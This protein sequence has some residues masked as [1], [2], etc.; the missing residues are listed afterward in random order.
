MTR[1]RVRWGNIAGALS[2][3]ASFSVALAADFDKSGTRPNTISLP[4]GPGS[5]EGMGPSFEPSLNDGGARYAIPLRLPPGPAGLVPELELSYD[6]GR[7]NGPLGFGWSLSLPFIQRQTDKGIPQ[8]VDGPNGVDDDLDGEFD[9]VDELDRCIT[10]HNEELVPLSNGYYFAE[11]E[12]TFIRYK[13]VGDGWEGQLPAGGRLYFG[14]NANSRIFDPSAPSNTFKWLLSRQTDLNGNTIT[15]D[16]SDFPGVADR[17]QKYLVAVR[18]GPGAGPPWKANHLAILQYGPRPDVL[19][20]GRGGFLIRTGQRLTNVLIGTQGVTLPG[21]R[22]ADLDGDGKLDALNRS[23]ALSYADR[24][25]AASAW[26]MLAEVTLFGADGVTR[27]PPTAFAYGLADPTATVSAADAI[28]GGTNEPVYGVD[29]GLVEFLDVNGDALPDILKTAYQG[30]PHIVYLNEGPVSD[31]PGAAIRWGRPQEMAS[32][33]GQAWNVNLEDTNTVSHLADLD[34]D[35]R[36]DLWYKTPGG[37]V[38][39]FRN[40]ADLSWGP[41]Q[42]MTVQDFAPPAPFGQTGVTTADLDFDKRIDI[43]QSIAVGGHTSFRTWYARD[44]ERYSRSSTVEQAVRFELAQPG[45][46]LT[47]FNGDR[48]PD[49]TRLRSSAVEV[50]AGLGYGRFAETKS[51][52][53]QEWTFTADEIARAK[54]RDLT[55]DGLPELVLERA[56]PGVLWYWINLGDYRFGPR[57][58]VTG[59]P[60]TVSRNAAVRWVDINGNGT[61]DLIYSD[62]AGNPRIMAVDIGQL[63]G[64]GNDWNLL[65]LIDNGIGLKTRIDYAPSTRFRLADKA[66][67]NHWRDPLPFPVSV[68]SCVVF[69]DSLG[70]AYTN[71]YRYRDGYYDPVEKEFRG[72]A[73]A[74]AVSH[75]AAD[76]PSL[77]AR[78]W[79]DT[80]RD[81][82]A[83]KG[84]LLQTTLAD[85]A[86]GIFSE[87]KLLWAEMPRTLYTGL[88]TQV[89]RFAHRTGSE[90]T[91]TEQGRGTPVTIKTTSAWDNFGNQVLDAN[92]GVVGNQFDDERIVTNLYAINEGAWLVRFPY[93]TLLMDEAGAVRSRS[94]RFY[95]DESFSGLNP[96]QVTAGRLTMVRDWID[97][98]SATNF[99]ES[100]RNQY[101]AR[102]N[103]IRILDP[104]ARLAAGQPQP[105]AGHYRELAYDDALAAFPLSETIHVGAGSDPLVYKAAFDVGLGTLTNSIDFNGHATA[106]RHDPLGRLAAILKPGDDPAFPSTEYDYQL[107]VPAG[108]SHLVNFVE[109]RLLDK[110][111]GSAG[112]VKR[113]HYLL[114]RAFVDGMGRVLLTKQEA[115]NGRVAVSGAGPFN[116]RGKPAAK[117]NP[118]FSLAGPDFE[119]RLAFENIEAPGWT[120]LFE[121]NGISCPLGLA[122]A[123]KVA[124]AYD[125][126]LREIK[127]TH[128]D[129]SFART[130]HEPLVERKYDEN[131]TDPA[132]PF[133]DTPHV[134]HHDG[135]G[136]LIQVDEIVRLND[137][138]TPSAVLN[139]WSTC[140][141]YDL[142]DQ[143]T[144]ILDSQNNLKTFAY[145]G[146]KR[147]TRLDD[148]NRGLMVF[149]YDAASNLRETTDAKNQLI[150]YGYDGANRL[151][152]EDYLDDHLSFSAH[153]TNDVRYVYDVPMP[154]IPMGD[155]TTAT[156][157]NTLGRLVY[158]IDLSGEEHT[159]YD[160][161]GRE[162]WV[163]KRIVNPANGLLT[164]YATWMSYDPADRLAILTYPDHDQLRHDYDDRGLLRKLE[165]G[166]FGVVISNKDYHA[167]GRMALCDYG[168][169]VRTSHT[170]DNRL[171]LHELFT[172]RV[173]DPENALLHFGY[174]FDRSINI[175]QIDDLRPGTVAPRNDPG[176][177]TQLYAYDDLNRLT[178]A[179]Y[180]FQLPG[181]S[182]QDDGR[183]HYRYDRIGNMLAQTSTLQQVENGVP[184]T[185]VGQME[186]GGTAG[187]WNRIGRKPVDP[188]GPHA[189][190]LV[191]NRPSAIGHR[192]FS[193]DANGN[194]LT[195]DGLA[196]TWDFRDRLVMATNAQ[197]VAIYTYDYTGRRIAKHIQ[198]SAQAGTNT[199]ADARYVSRFYELR[200]TAPP[201]RYAWDGADCV[202]RATPIGT[203]GTGG[204]T[205]IVYYGQDHLHSTALTVDRAGRPKES[206]AYHPFGA[207]RRGP[208]PAAGGHIYGFGQKEQDAETSLANFE[209]RC[210]QPIL[211]RFTAVDPISIGPTAS[212]LAQPQLLNAY[213]YAGNQPLGFHDPDG[214]SATVIGAVVGGI[215]FGLAEIIRNDKLTAGSLGKAIAVGIVSGAFAGS[216]IDSGGATLGLAGLS[217]AGTAGALA[218]TAA[219]GFT[220]GATALGLENLLQGKSTGPDELM[221]AGSVSAAASVVGDLSG[222]LLSR[223]A[224]KLITRSAAKGGGKGLGNPF[225]DKTAAQID[226][227]FTKKGY[228]KIGPDP[229]GGTGGYV[230]P[231]TGRSYHIDPKDWGKYREPNHVDVNRLRDYKGPLDKKKLPY[232]EE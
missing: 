8:Y 182:A 74:E 154:A 188:P 49:Q 93:R 62:S 212:S 164:S 52:P 199:W 197:M 174:T 127:L 61:T 165:G 89:V 7:G 143:L 214:K 227:M 95:D 148:P 224:S 98:A 116:R 184:V 102:G 71:D 144:T 138:G 17:A 111:P 225:K 117:L 149:V 78:S 195:I 150:R 99:V 141:G 193:Y 159:S 91:I 67:T 162:C 81:F 134:Y 56:A 170:Y 123:P 2:L 23:Y 122:A 169:G 128:P 210:L 45:V 151:L 14:E 16:Y 179:Q 222:Q 26:S 112:A 65:K 12:S 1:A 126:T 21:H 48:V 79:F 152:F 20:D 223:V 5:I 36:A 100:V 85:E 114:S 120:G 33:D 39:F 40:E 118:Y 166:S 121:T 115:G 72:F 70:H 194:M 205:E 59:L 110:V 158:V 15:Y 145:D 139:T 113:D 29:N 77:V 75:G 9:E 178:R 106:Y 176:R 190:T 51:V 34:G 90:K 42:R 60:T 213:S 63:I 119:A 84:K 27:L 216:V 173:A 167:D 180:S 183:I 31:A 155:G 129:G 209:A 58:I 206:F 142:N 198:P 6:S 108:G 22:T 103:I 105:D 82:E 28:M 18:Y 13:R 55:G 50:A 231:E 133:H 161:R 185:D 146:L 168:N 160:A 172:R 24:P 87:E 177:N 124:I 196:C 191:S 109:T 136:R 43:V 137:D 226:D 171:R 68:V 4:K 19:E 220:G 187:R 232:L 215:G 181:E 46:E 229:A 192:Q 153:R 37:E 107:A 3:L 88:N 200:G 201:V 125:A 53:I 73:Q 203:T 218:T 208:G 147:K 86:G 30:G 66:Q 163:N 132:S 217:S 38:F 101:D 204:Q 97:P 211:G 96:G 69:N 92:F 32:R 35:G 64:F 57:R 10:D 202:A 135:L 228:T 130:D 186:S 80:G 76:A 221:I 11:N 41:R 131:D 140:Y 157:S 25:G 189:L 175:T 207:T 83:M 156:A 230:N 104:L 94:E 47:D 219:S 54:L 44:G